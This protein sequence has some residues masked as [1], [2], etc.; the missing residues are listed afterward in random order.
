MTLWIVFVYLS[1][2]STITHCNNYSSVRNTIRRFVVVGMYYALIFPL[3]KQCKKT[4]SNQRQHINCLS[5]PNRIHIEMTWNTK[6]KNYREVLLGSGIIF[7][8]MLRVLNRMDVAWKLMSEH[9]T[10]RNLIWGLLGRELISE[11][12]HTRACFINRSRH[13]T[14]YKSWYALNPLTNQPTMS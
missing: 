1:Y 8:Y 13:G 7:R 6:R 9:A 12:A 2:V 5:K 4:T 3:P 11:N 10:V 14:N